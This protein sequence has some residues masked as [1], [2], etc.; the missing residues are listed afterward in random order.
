MSLIRIELDVS[1]VNVF[2]KTHYSA[3]P[4]TIC[5]EM[6]NSINSFREKEICEFSKYCKISVLNKFV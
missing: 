1:P 5:T 4:K 6:L 2:A 3:G